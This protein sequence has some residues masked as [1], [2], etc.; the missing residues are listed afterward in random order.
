MMT[1][2][3][4]RLTVE[5]IKAHPFFY[6]AD[7]DRLRYIAPPFVPALRSITDTTYFPTDDFGN[8]PD[9]LQ[10]VEALGSE[11][12]L[13]F[14][15]C[16]SPFFTLL[17]RFT[18]FPDSRSSGPLDFGFLFSVLL[19]YTSMNSPA[20]LFQ[21]NPLIVIIESAT[22]DL[23]SLKGVYGNLPWRFDKNFSQM[24]RCNVAW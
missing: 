24:L 19:P 5:G 15:G 4:N 7:W 21:A 20:Y 16:A 11:S 3:E 13:A 12:D 18:P 8:L 22:S 17:F 10:A 6:G 9:Q 23:V 2:A 1:W 14:I